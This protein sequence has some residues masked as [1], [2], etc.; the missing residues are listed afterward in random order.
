MLA[1][2]GV[3][4]IDALF[5]VIPADVRLG[6]PLA[7]EPSLDEARLMDHMAALADK[8]GGG[9]GAVV[10][11]R[12]HLRAPR[13]P[14]RRPAPAAERVL[15]G[16]HALPGRG[17]ARDAAGNLRVS[18]DRERALR[19]AGRQ[20]VDVRRRERCGRGG[21]DGAAANEAHA[22]A[23]KRR[24]SP[25]IRRRRSARTFAAYRKGPR[26]SRP[27]R[28]GRAARWISRRSKGRSRGAKTS[29]A[30][31]SVTR[32]SSAACRTSGRPPS[33]RTRTARS[34]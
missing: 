12:G 28:S 20:R 15:H 18:D 29:R 14:R 24:G 27:S 9:P 7:I 32:T 23:R 21:A 8:N 2:I 6:R 4:S 17:G 16:V 13:P 11:R 19:A 30:S 33:S 26:R 1:A 22:R 5:D 34:W 25:G 3:P 10:P 31:S